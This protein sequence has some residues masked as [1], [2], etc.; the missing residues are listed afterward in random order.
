MR[1]SI[2]NAKN[3]EYDAINSLGLTIGLRVI[4]G[5]HSQPCAKYPKY[6][7]PKLASESRTPIRDDCHRKSM[8]T[9]HTFDKLHSFTFTIDGV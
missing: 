5:R 9:N 6:E 7:S 8:L 2:N 1:I 4:C 3:I